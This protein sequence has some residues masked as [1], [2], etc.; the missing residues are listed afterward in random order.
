[1]EARAQPARREIDTSVAAVSGGLHGDSGKR[2]DDEE[3][4][5]HSTGVRADA[6]L[7][8][9]RRLG[10]RVLGRVGDGQV[11]VMGQPE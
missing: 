8:G 3:K 5:A 1:M 7:V 10:C 11:Q 4:G 2:D 6:V 9:L